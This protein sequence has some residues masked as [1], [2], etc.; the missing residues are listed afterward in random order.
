[1]QIAKNIEQLDNEFVKKCQEIQN[2]YYKK[3]RYVPKHFE[4]QGLDNVTGNASL[5]E[6]FGCVYD[7][8]LPQA[9]KAFDWSYDY[10]KSL[11]DR[12]DAYRPAFYSESV[13]GFDT[14]VWMYASEALEVL[15]KIKE[16]MQEV[17]AA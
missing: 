6:F 16:A 1:M 5:Y 8:D 11:R 15:N 13:C 17:F 7:N 3:E 9:K 10:I 4:N 14:L 2:L 12:A